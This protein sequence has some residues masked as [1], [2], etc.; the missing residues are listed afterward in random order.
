[1]SPATPSSVLFP[2]DSRTG[3]AAFVEPCF[4]CI[5]RCSAV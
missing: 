4:S 2:D 3:A 1:L 5:L